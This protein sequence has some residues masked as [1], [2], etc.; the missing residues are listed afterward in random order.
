MNPIL[1][2]IG[3]IE[4]RWYSVLILTAFIV[5]YFLVRNR[6]KKDN[7]DIILVSDLICYLVLVAIIGARIYYCL[8]NLDYY[9]M[10][11]ISIFKIWEGGLAIHGGVIAGIIFCYFYTKKKNLDL[12]KI[13]DI[14]APALALGQAIGR[15][16]NFFNSEAFGPITSLKTLQGLH[17]PKFIIDGMYIDGFYHHPTFFYESL[18]CLIIFVILMIFRN[19]MKKGQ[20]SGTYFILYGIIRF[21]IESLRQDS[22]MLGNIK[23]AQL[24]SIISIL[25]G[26]YLFIKPYLRSNYDK[27][28]VGHSTKG[29]TKKRIL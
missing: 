19:K 23:I 17:I 9:L 18:G 2:S 14:I 7:I 15:W 26:I 11:P 3:S 20:V 4:I 1:V 27:Q 22:L 5:G 21:L 13:L 16:G 29:R 24:V 28:K 12:L 6:C 25:A 10:D 8:F